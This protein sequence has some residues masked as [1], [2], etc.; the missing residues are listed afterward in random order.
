[1]RTLE[2]IREEIKK[3]KA[4]VEFC[5][6]SHQ[7]LEDRFREVIPKMFKER[8]HIQTIMEKMRYYEKVMKEKIERAEKHVQI[9]NALENLLAE[10]EE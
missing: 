3:E 7:Q 5:L 2:K 8:N 10:Q 1:M 4:N 6:K 9:M